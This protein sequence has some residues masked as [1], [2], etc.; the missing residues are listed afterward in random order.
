MVR[1]DPETRATLQK[2]RQRPVAAERG[3]SLAQQISADSFVECSALT[4]EG[5]K[6]VFEYAVRATLRRTRKRRKKKSCVVS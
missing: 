4:L 5:V 3:S 1:D 2:H 6:E